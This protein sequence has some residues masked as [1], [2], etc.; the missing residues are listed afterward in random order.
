MS[1]DRVLRVWPD[2]TVEHVPA[3]IGCSWV[4]SRSIAGFDRNIGLGESEIDCW[5]DITTSGTFVEAEA[6]LDGVCTIPPEGWSCTRKR[7][8]GAPCAAVPSPGYG[9]NQECA[10]GFCWRNPETGY[11]EYCAVHES[12]IADQAMEIDRSRNHV[13]IMEMDLRQL[14]W[15][16]GGH[17]VDSNRV[18][19]RHN[20]EIVVAYEK[21]RK[22]AHGK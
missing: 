2:V 20:R 5:H 12:V 15:D 17:F 21:G 10:G 13:K 8:H 18:V 6:E 9:L 16:R 14:E 22:D 1:R 7:G 11:T 3:R 4:A 19:D